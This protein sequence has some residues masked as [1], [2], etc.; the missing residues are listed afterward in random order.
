MLTV[1]QDLIIPLLESLYPANPDLVSIPAIC[2]SVA[3]KPDDLETFNHYWALMARESA[4][5][6]A[7]RDQVLSSLAQALFTFLLRS[8]PLMTTQLVV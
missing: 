4:N 8:I 5:S 1:R 6:Y 7:G 3:D 2:L